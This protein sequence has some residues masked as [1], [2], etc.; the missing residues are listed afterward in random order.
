VLAS[1]LGHDPDRRPARVARI[2]E[3]IWTGPA[4][5]VQ[6]RSSL[7]VHGVRLHFVSARPSEGAAHP[8][9]ALPLA[10]PVLD[11]GPGQPPIIAR[12]AWAQG[13]G[14]RVS[15]A[16]GVIRMAFVHH[17]QNPNGYS[18]DQVP[19]MLL[20]IYQ[21][22][23][24]VRGWNDIGYNFV[25]DAVGRIWEARQGGIDQAVIGAQAGG[26]NAE[27]TGVAVLG[28]FMDVL[29]SAAAIDALERL[30]SWKLALHGVPARG[31]VTVVVDPATAFY[32]PFRPGAHVSLPRV[33]GHRDGDSTD[34]PGDAFYDQLPSI[35]PVI[36]GL[37][38]VPVKLTLTASRQTAIAPAAVELSGRAATLDGVPLPGI[39]LELQQLAGSGTTAIAN[40]VSASDGTFVAPLTLVRTLLVRAAHPVRPAAVSDLLQIAVAPL[41]QLTVTGNSPVQVSG[42]VSPSKRAVTVEVLARQGRGHRRVVLAKRAAVRRGRFTCKLRIGRRGSYQVRVR[43]AADSANI[44]GVS[45]LVPL[46]L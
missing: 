27:S 8:A 26:Y 15:P 43:T 9:D 33:A 12:S 45:P 29:P 41:I 19:A 35:R 25:I 11:A 4:D 5:R 13:I 7:P 34:C 46:Q 39:P 18:A 37:E 1:V 10:Q 31:R 21:F 17:T 24:F 36:A 44:A 23:R 6:V 32:T 14:P 42:T 28:S 30:L 40:V 2:G 22:H 20:A 3:A 16:Y 38:G